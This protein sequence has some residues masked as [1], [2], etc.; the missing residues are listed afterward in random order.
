MGMKIGGEGQFDMLKKMGCEP[1]PKKPTEAIFRQWGYVGASP[2]VGYTYNF[3]TNHGTYLK[4]LIS[5]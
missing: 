2:L 4:N 1:N 3:V 5:R